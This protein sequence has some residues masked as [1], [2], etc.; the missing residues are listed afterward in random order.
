MA[1]AANS[2]GGEGIEFIFMQEVFCIFVESLKELINMFCKSLFIKT[3]TSKRSR[4]W[5]YH[6]DLNRGIKVLQTFALPLGDGTILERK[7]GLE[8]ATFALARQRSTTEPLPQTCMPSI[9]C[10]PQGLLL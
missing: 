2:T 9:C 10:A 7:T 6:P 4:F 5:R 1:L 3:A 8:P